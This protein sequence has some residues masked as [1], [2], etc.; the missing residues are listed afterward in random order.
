MSENQ[1]PL[2]PNFKSVDEALTKGPH[3]VTRATRQHIARALALMPQ[4][5]QDEFVF[6]SPDVVIFIA[7]SDIAS[8]SPRAGNIPLGHTVV[9]DQKWFALQPHSQVGALGHELAHVEYYRKN[10][11]VSSATDGGEME[12]DAIAASWGIGEYLVAFFENQLERVD[13]DETRQ[14]FTKKRIEKV[15]QIMN[16]ARGG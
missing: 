4:V 2:P 1:E 7:S 3:L 6:R 9:L 10:G 11:T 8:C 14:T 16:A 13:L 15:R 12:I 5:L